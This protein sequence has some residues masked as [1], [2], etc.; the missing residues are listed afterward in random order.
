MDL[1]VGLP[2]AGAQASAD[3]MV[4]IAKGA[5][6]L[7]Y[8]AVWAFERLL[9]ALGDISQPGGPP[10]P[11]PKVYGCVYEPIE[12]LAFVAAHTSTIRL[13]TSVVVIP[14]HGP[15]SIARRLATLDQL[16]GGR[17][18]A[19]FGQGWMDQ[20]FTAAGV[21]KNGA[22]RRT[23]EFVEV[24]RR[25]WGPDPVEF[26]G[27]V[28]TVPRSRIQ[29]KPLQPG[30]PPILLGVFAPSAVERAARIAD[31][32]NPIAFSYDSLAGT[33]AR[34]RSA[35]EAAGRG[36]PVVMARANVAMTPDPL[37]DDRPFLGGAPEQIAEDL[38]RVEELDIDQVFFSNQAATSIDDQLRLLERLRK[39]YP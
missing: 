4:R 1:G 11:L 2:S 33:V 17:V 8:R 3:G 13:G 23:R 26:E 15:V 21:S 30:G 22:G 37:G 5:E 39:A 14:F 36:K 9:Y 6:Q 7:G 35:A 24:L 25:A 34:F 31:G 16:S 28:Y 27:R 29:P 32:F 18:I 20:E 10:R 19:G 38:K 12:S